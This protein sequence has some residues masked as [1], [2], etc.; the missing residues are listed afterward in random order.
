ML[1]R[2]SNRSRPRRTSHRRIDLIRQ[3]GGGNRL[4]I[5]IAVRE[6]IE[7]VTV[8]L[9]VQPAQILDALKKAGLTS[10]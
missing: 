2:N 10:E 5:G 3:I 4:A 8:V 9:A 6:L 7:E 1:K